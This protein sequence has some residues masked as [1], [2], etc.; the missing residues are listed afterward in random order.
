LLQKENKFH[1]QRDYFFMSDYLNQRATTGSRKRGEICFLDCK[2][3][4]RNFSLVAIARAK[5]NTAQ[6]VEQCEESEKERDAE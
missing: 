2:P 3:L 4:K 1:L 6:K 5:S